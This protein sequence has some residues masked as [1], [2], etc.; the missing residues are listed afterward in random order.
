[1]PWRLAP[2]DLGDPGCGD[3]W[4]PH[5]AFFASLTFWYGL[6]LL[7]FFP[8]FLL[9]YHVKMIQCY[10]FFSS[11]IA[12]VA[13]WLGPYM[14]ISS[15]NIIVQGPKRSGS[16]GKTR[17]TKKHTPKPDDPQIPQP[18][19]RFVKRNSKPDTR[20]GQE[21]KQKHPQK[22]FAM[23]HSGLTTASH[24]KTCQKWISHHD[25]SETWKSKHSAHGRHKLSYREREDNRNNRKRNTSRKKKH[26]GATA[27][28]GPRTDDTMLSLVH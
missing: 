13:L 27:R 7:M 11:S 5:G 15:K 6:V 16:A 14:S 4:F 10:L 20:K 17:Q 23:R 21:P 22:R 18:D 2:C 19:L 3:P 25:I 26:R 8:L 1:M 12:D 28:E 24:S 9:L